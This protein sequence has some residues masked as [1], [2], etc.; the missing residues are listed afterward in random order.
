MHFLGKMPSRFR[1]HSELLGLE[2]TFVARRRLSGCLFCNIAAMRWTSCEVVK[3]LNRK[4]STM[5]RSTAKMVKG[6][7]PV[8]ESISIA[9]VRHARHICLRYLALLRRSLSESSLVVW[10][11][12]ADHAGLRYREDRA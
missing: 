5:Y 10:V 11:G 1:G 7:Y 12:N 8:S 9:H 2:A 6:K 4:G 3:V